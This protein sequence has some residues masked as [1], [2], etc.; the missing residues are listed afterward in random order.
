M[1]PVQRDVFHGILTHRLEVC[2]PICAAQRVSGGWIGLSGT[3]EPNSGWKLWPEIGSWH[4]IV[5]LI[6]VYNIGK[7]L[8]FGSLVPRYKEAT[9]SL[10]IN[11][12]A[13]NFIAQ[14]TEGEID[15]HQWIGDSYAILFSHPKD[16]TPV[17]TTEL[18][19]M[20]GL[21][22]EVDPIPDTVNQHL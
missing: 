14:T 5:I 4:E 8:P 3:Q 10:R 20:A 19:Y 7:S 2:W 18:G 16:F 21:A 13:P 22:D 1:S 12:T 15:F 11:D 9:M 17:C 6:L